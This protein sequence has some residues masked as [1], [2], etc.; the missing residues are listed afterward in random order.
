MDKNRINFIK[1]STV[2][3]DKALSEE[4]AKCLDEGNGIM[5]DITAFKDKLDRE[6]MFHVDQCKHDGPFHIFESTDEAMCAECKTVFT[7]NEYR[8]ILRSIFNA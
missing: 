2:F 7:I 8:L 6:E 3:Y 5:K 1:E 4:L